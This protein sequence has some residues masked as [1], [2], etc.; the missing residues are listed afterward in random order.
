MNTIGGLIVAGG[1]SRRMGEN[2]ALLPFGPRR[3]VDHIIERLRVQC[4]V[5]ALNTN[6]TITGIHGLAMVPD[7]ISGFA[8][9]LA[10]IAAGLADLKRRH[11]T[12]THLL[13]V[14]ADTPFFPQTLARDLMALVGEPDEIAVASSADGAWH[15]VFALWPV[16]VEADLRAWLADPENRRLRAFIG[17]RPHQTV[18]FPL[19][20]GPAGSIDPFFNI[21]T[22]EDYRRALA[23]L[24]ETA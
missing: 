8:G 7:D 2:K 11:P 9:P 1:L 14:A 4:P 6:E 24:E 19:I 3:L 16:G 15:P 21:N 18:P 23:Y 20:D 13:S 22:P 17:Q 5:L 10:G 12:A